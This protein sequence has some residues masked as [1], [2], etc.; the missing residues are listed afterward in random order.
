MKFLN[1]YSTIALTTLEPLTS[2]QSVESP[3]LTSTTIS[4]SLACAK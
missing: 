4:V 2:L 3:V 1:I